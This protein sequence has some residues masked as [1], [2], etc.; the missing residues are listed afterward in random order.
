MKVAI[1][2]ENYLIDVD[3][4]INLAITYSFSDLTNPANI[5]G[6]YSKTITIK[7]TQTN[8]EIFGQIWR[9]DRSFLDSS[10]F[11]A[12]VHFNASK[13]ADCKI[14]IN[15][16]LFKSGYLKLNSVNNDRGVISYEVTFYSSLCNALHTLQEKKLID[17]PFTNNLKH[18]I[19]KNAINSF[20]NDTHIL[21]SNMN[22]VMANNGLYEDFQ[23][24]K[25]MTWN[26]GATKPTIVDI[27]GGAELDE[28]AKGEYRS[29]HQRPALKI[30]NLIDLIGADASI[31][32]DKNF[33][34]SNNPYY[35]ESYLTMP[36]LNTKETLEVYTGTVSETPYYSEQVEPEASST[37]DV[38]DYIPYEVK[39]DSSIFQTE[40]VINLDSL[41]GISSLSV[42]AQ[43]RV[44]IT[45]D[46]NLPIGTRFFITDTSGYPKLNIGMR[47]EDSNGFANEL[48]PYSGYDSSVMLDHSGYI[49][50]NDGSVSSGY[51]LFPNKFTNYKNGEMLT[52]L[53]IHFKSDERVFQDEYT[54]YPHFEYKATTSYY[55]TYGNLPYVTPVTT[56]YITIEVLPI[57][58]L[59]NE[60]ANPSDYYPAF[61]INY[62]NV[63]T[64]ND[65]VINNI[66]TIQSNTI[67]DK[68]DIIDDEITQGDF[69]I[70]Y[71]KLFGLIMY[72][73]EAGNLDIVSRNDYFR[74][75][76]ILDWESKIDYSQQI[77]Q[78]PIVFDKKYIEFKYTDGET[79]YENYYDNKFGVEY[80]SAKLNTGY[81][82]NSDTLELVQ[83]CMFYNT[84]MSKEKTNMLTGTEYIFS[85]DEKI[86]PAL[87]QLQD[88]KRNQ[89]DTKFNLLFDNGLISLNK[90]I[91]ISDDDE[92]MID[93][94]LGVEG[95]GEPC[96]IDTNN[97]TMMSRCGLRKGAYRQFSTLRSDGN[98]SWDIG[99]PR[100]NYAGWTPTNY[101]ESATIYN[102]FW[103]SYLSEIYNVDNKLV[104]CYIKLDLN[105]MSQ[106][107]F[108]NFI[109]AFGCL[110]HVNKIN[111]Y[112]PLSDKPTEVE[113]I[114]VSDINAYISSQKFFERDVTITYNLTS[115]ISSNT[116]TQILTGQSYETTLTP[117]TAG[118][119][120]QD[121]AQYRIQSVIVT[122]GGVDITDTALD[123]ETQ[124][125]LIPIVSD[126]ITITARAVRDVM[127]IEDELL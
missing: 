113:M 107:S 66:M 55:S 111:N 95:A 28:C 70:N 114:K 45:F 121:P 13:R 123:R 12:G 87:F 34:T 19:S 62:E 94:T 4:D 119:T 116:D 48:T 30:S 1:Y 63:Y 64:S 31:N 25:M 9:F 78:T 126:D 101:S 32:L 41:K 125:I 36:N 91:V 49:S 52:E 23:N 76:K 58:K 97:I 42:E 8:N 7:G 17:L 112:N 21:A 69:L 16:G 80:G 22:Y 40:A 39:A 124:T 106:F 127:P 120:E 98:F 53:P 37:I 6:D 72:T 38:P 65:L 54:I 100:E 59:P 46:A 81:Q 84:V 83:D 68:K 93:E 73:D 44:K 82:F 109:K 14:Y 18:T 75:Y 89:S 35:S 56:K 10:L 92:Y 77:K 60:S 3:N 2:L 104:K 61:G 105:D 122:M 20:W 88:N 85:I 96:W 118:V 5:T 57:S 110:W 51:L 67:I 43:I 33:F 102:N 74:D 103:K 79:Q 108:K 29:Y 27:A 24:A 99:Y 47:L 117:S 115:V 90:S 86:L 15:G 71:A 50:E 11:N 26:S